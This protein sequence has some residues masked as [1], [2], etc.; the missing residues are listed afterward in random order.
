VLHTYIHTYICI[1][2]QKGQKPRVRHGRHMCGILKHQNYVVTYIHICIY[3]YLQIYRHARNH[4]CDTAD[5]CVASKN[6][7]TMLL[8]IYIC[9]YI[10][11]YKYTDTL[12]TT[13]ATWQTYVWHL[14]TPE[15]CV[16]HVHM[17]TNIQ[18]R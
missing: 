8:H 1:H 18:T 14:K 3:T 10:H 12:E 6:T 13:C 17:Y 2:T 9:I 15:P 7:R 16:L 4:V 11:I 5:I